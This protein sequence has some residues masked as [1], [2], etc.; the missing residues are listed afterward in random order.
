M[1]EWRS[2]EPFAPG[3]LERAL[4]GIAGAAGSALLRLKGVARVAGEASPRAV[5]AV[6]HTLYPCPR[7]PPV[8]P[9]ER[10]TRLVFAGRGLEES[11]IASILDSFRR[12]H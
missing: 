8:P 7:L 1:A 4:E 12:T 6:G 3:D 10:S 2:P 5:H 9:A 11:A